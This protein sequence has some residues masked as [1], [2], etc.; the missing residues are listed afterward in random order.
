V[1]QKADVHVGDFLEATVERGKITFT[2]KSVVDCV[3]QIS[4][5]DERGKMSPIFASAQDLVYHFHGQAKK[6]KKSK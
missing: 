1:R 2:L 6:L 3:L 4:A 5:P